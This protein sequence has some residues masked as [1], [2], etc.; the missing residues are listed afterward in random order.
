[1]ATILVIDEYPGFHEA[2]A[3]CLPK[4]GHCLLSAPDA[5]AG[6]ILALEK[7]PDL[8]LIDAGRSGQGFSLCAALGKDEALQTLPRIIM[9]TQV[10]QIASAKARAV[11]ADAI[12]SKP[13]DWP[14]FLELVE[15]LARK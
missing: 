12:L 2:M 5:A 9:T 7:R 10:T 3:Y 4:F 11:G 8:I 1:M 6:K 15:R 14:E 13:F